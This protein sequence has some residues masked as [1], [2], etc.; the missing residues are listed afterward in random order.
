LCSPNPCLLLFVCRHSAVICCLTGL[1]NERLHVRRLR[2][3][4]AIA[5]IAEVS[6]VGAWWVW[7][8]VSKLVTAIF[9]ICNC[10]DIYNGSNGRE[11]VGVKDSDLKTTIPKCVNMKDMDGVLVSLVLKLVPAIPKWQLE[12]M[13]TGVV[14]EFHGA[15]CCS[16]RLLLRS[17]LGAA[18]RAP[19][20]SPMSPARASSP[21]APAGVIAGLGATAPWSTS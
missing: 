9:S 19:H 6:G 13:L 21:G 7:I 10:G 1:G 18:R 5:A 16:I 15:W 2:V 8:A 12:F 20:C 4:T 11:G 14:R 17:S 3:A